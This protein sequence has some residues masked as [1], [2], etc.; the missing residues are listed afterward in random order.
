VQDQVARLATSSQRARRTT[1]PLTEGPGPTSCPESL[2]APRVACQCS[3]AGFDRQHT[4]TWIPQGNLTRKEEREWESSWKA[5]EVVQFE[6]MCKSPLTEG[7]W[8]VFIPSLTK[9]SR[10]WKSIQILRVYIRI[11]RILFPDIPDR[12]L[13]TPVLAETL[14]VIILK[15]FFAHKYLYGFS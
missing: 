2:P 8:G 12:D 14:S 5:C 6:K 15:W 11:L 1:G 4:L 13:E 7:V 9:T 10:W 3:P